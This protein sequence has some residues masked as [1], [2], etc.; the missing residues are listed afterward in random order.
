MYLNNLFY[1]FK[2]I[3]FMVSVYCI[4][5]YYVLQF[6]YSQAKTEQ[7]KHFISVNGVSYASEIFL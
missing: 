7:A 1:D 2:N 3:H 6:L 5:I 4:S